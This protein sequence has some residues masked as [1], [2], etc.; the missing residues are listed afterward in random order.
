MRGTEV[1]Q[2]EEIRKIVWAADEESGDGSGKL[3]MLEFCKQIKKG[4]LGAHLSVLGLDL[5]LDSDEKTVRVV[6][7]LVFHE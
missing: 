1:E 7:E 4:K 2:Y 5:G 6:F 3:G